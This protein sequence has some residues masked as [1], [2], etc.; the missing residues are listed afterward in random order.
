[1]RSETIDYRGSRPGGHG[2]Y[3]ETTTIMTKPGRIRGPGFVRTAGSGIKNPGRPAPLAW[4]PPAARAPASPSARCGAPLAHRPGEG[5]RQAGEAE[6]ASLLVSD[7]EHL[8]AQR[9]AGHGQHAHAG[10]YR[11]LAGGVAGHQREAVQHAEGQAFAESHQR[12]A[13]HHEVLR[14]RGPQH[15]GQHQT[16]AKHDGPHAD[17]RGTAQRPAPRHQHQRQIAGDQAAEYRQLHQAILQRAHVQIMHQQDRRH[18]DPAHQRQRQQRMHN[19]DS[20][21]RP[22]PNTFR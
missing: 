11:A 14:V 15:A 13:G 8:H 1:M 6:H 12:H 16:Q 4:F 18:G 21:K 22:L 5:Q 10:R 7:A 3:P 9:V 17:Q 2:G 19:A 20:T